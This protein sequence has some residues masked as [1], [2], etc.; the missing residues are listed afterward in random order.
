MMQTKDIYTKYKLMPQL[1]KHQLRVAG[2]AKLITNTW[3]D[4]A[5]AQ[6]AVRACLMHDMGNMAKFTGLTDPYWQDEQ[7]KFW[8]KYGHKEHA[9]TNMILQELGLTEVLAVLA[10]E[11]SCYRSQQPD[12]QATGK[13]AL[14]VMYADLRVT[15][16]GVVPMYTRI[17]DLVERYPNK[18][19]PEMAW[20]SE[21]ERYVQI[22]TPLKLDMITEERVK[23]L[24]GDLLALE[25]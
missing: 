12:F 9:A 11:E 24:F 22:T 15:M 17:K 6:L 14:M 20:G 16:D 3:D 18:N 7:K 1:I 2:A 13:A 5:L 23:P 4:K 8:E 25:W 10:D 21:L 19:L